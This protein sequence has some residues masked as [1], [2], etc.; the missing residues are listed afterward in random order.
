MTGEA[1]GVILAGQQIFQL[2]E[3]V[4]KRAVG[5]LPV[6]G[7]YRV[8]DFMLSNLVNSGI[9][10][11]AVI[12]GRNYNSLMDHLGSGKS[13]D[14]SRKSD[15]LFIIPPFATADNPGTY[16]GAVDALKASMDY[17]QRAKQEYCII[18]GAFN[19]FKIDFDDVLRNHIEK[20]ADITVLYNKLGNERYNG[21]RYDDVRFKIN[22]K[23]EVIK[24]ERDMT[25]SSLDC[26]SMDTFVIRK[27][28]LTYLVDD[29][30]SKNEYH[31]A[32]QLVGGNLE[33]LKV[34]GWEHKGYTGRMHSIAAYYGVNMDMLDSKIRSQLFGGGSRI[35]TKIKD[36]VPARYHKTAKVSNSLIANGCIIEGEVENSVLFRGVYVGKGTRIKNSII[37]P[38]TE[39]NDNAELEYVVLDKDVGVRNRTRLIGNEQFPV[40]IRKGVVV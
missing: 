6:A 13:W 36:E 12:T 7:R 40:V 26:M 4:D 8:I 28:I 32:E 1:F 15:G 38:G 16:R 34:I 39:I 22:S 37:L 29:C 30:I 10:N 20:G 19:I 33:R 9:R 21:E 18:S 11:V 14:L 23:K 17:I 25:V 31:F 3:L 5:A 35:Y 27:D 2:R 24:V